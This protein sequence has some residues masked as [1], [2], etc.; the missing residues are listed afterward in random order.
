MCIQDRERACDASEVSSSTKSLEPTMSNT[1]PSVP[2]ASVNPQARASS[3][4]RDDARSP[5]A[6][7]MSSPASASDSRRFWACRV[8]GVEGFRV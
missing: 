3:L 7:L 1:S 4:E 8:D 6:T 2:A 5:M